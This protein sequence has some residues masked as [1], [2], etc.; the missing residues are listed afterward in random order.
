ME[1]GAKIKKL[2]TSKMMTQSELAGHQITR[3]MLSQIENGLA[4]PSLS[5]ILYIAERLNVPAG[6]LLA[7]GDDEFIGQTH[8]LADAVD[9][10]FLA[11]HRFVDEDLG[12]KIGALGGKRLYT[13]DEEDR[14]LCHVL[15]DHHLSGADAFGDSR[16]ADGVGD[17]MYSDVACQSSR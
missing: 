1:I 5:T 9:L 12:F 8:S 13:G 6:F 16:G 7:E 17:L 15:I 11:A 10:T 4:L 3:N 14:D 2:R